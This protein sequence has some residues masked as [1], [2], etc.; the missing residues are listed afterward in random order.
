MT[1]NLKR[2]LNPLICVVAGLFNFIFMFL[3]YAAIFASQNN[4]SESYGFSSYGFLNFGDDSPANLL[5]ELLELFGKEANAT[6]LI[7][8]VAILIIAMIILSVGLIFLGS[9]GLVREFA[10]VNLV[11]NVAP[12]TINHFSK[13]LLKF[14][15]AA[16]IGAALS[17]LMAC[18]INLYTGEVYGYKISMGMKPEIG[19]YFLLIFAIAEWIFY[20]KAEKKFAGTLSEEKVLYKCS[21]CGTKAKETDKFCSSC[22]GAIVPQETTTASTESE[23]VSEENNDTAEENIKNFDYSV[24]TGFFKKLWD[25]LKSFLKK[26]KISPKILGIIAG[27]LLVIIIAI[28]ILV[29]IPWPKAAGYIIPENDLSFAY[30][31]TEDQTYIISSGKKEKSTIDGEIMQSVLSIDGNT[32]ALLAEDETLYIYKNSS[33]ITAAEYVKNFKLSSNG[34][35]VA[36][37][38][39]DEELVLYTIEDKK[40]K[41]ITDEVVTETTSYQISPDGKSIAYAEGDLDEFSM[42]VFVDG[43]KKEID[44]N[45]LP[46]GL[47][48]NASLIYYYNIEKSSVYVVGEDE[49]PIKLTNSPNSAYIPL[50]Y[51][52]DHTQVLIAS[53]SNWYIAVNGGEKQKISSKGI[54]QFG[55]QSAWITA[56]INGQTVITTPIIDFAE[57]YFIDSNGTL[58]YLTETFDAVEIA[59]NI[60]SFKTTAAGEIVYYLEEYGDLYR[61]EG[62]GKDFEQIAEDVESFVITSDGSG[63]YY[64]DYDSTLRYVKG[65]GNSEKIADDIHNLYITHDNYAIFLS[66]YSE[67]NGG[68]LYSSTNGN[69]KERISD[70]VVITRITSKGTYYYCNGEDD[71]SYDI[72]GAAEGVDFDLIAEGVRN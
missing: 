38:N 46:L 69:E 29:N 67:Q 26:Y 50:V 36:Y 5:S 44:E 7:V 6:V 20:L 17:L 27:I 45:V 34:T 1:I 60:G 14:Y 12:K 47:A 8:F 63:C 54:S 10:G 72:F 59:D 31:E 25:N 40:S 18:F 58:Y 23:S 64:V 2:L 42:Y 55:N 13:M 57:E 68:T 32:L 24:I 28:I 56:F 3:N 33:L 39:D 62:Y 11:G 48:D 53:D 9:V 22:G 41:T 19:M 21:L 35:S 70:D 65:T 66:D 52:S 71:S 61:G 37:I 15:F 49:N 30:S 51:N 4:E 16:N 43:K